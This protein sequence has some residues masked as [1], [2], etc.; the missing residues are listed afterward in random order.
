MVVQYPEPTQKI[1]KMGPRHKYT[2][3][4]ALYKITCTEMDGI[5]GVSLSEPHTRVTEFAELC[6]LASYGVVVRTGQ[7][8]ISRI[9]IT[10]KDDK[11]VCKDAVH[12]GALYEHTT[13][14]EGGVTILNACVL[15]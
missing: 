7:D 4:G 8:T 10:C 9:N 14:V 13:V 15:H 5:I 3:S 1:S 11:I 2:G 12:T 6:H